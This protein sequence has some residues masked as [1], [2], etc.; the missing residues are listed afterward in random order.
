MPRPSLRARP[1]PP[2]PD[3][4]T[5]TPGSVVAFDQ[6]VRFEPSL[7]GTESAYS[8]T[9]T[10]IIPIVFLGRNIWRLYGPAPELDR[11][12][13]EL[14]HHGHRHRHRHRRPPQLP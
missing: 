2:R 13:R 6:R 12:Q 3:Q 5:E 1:L 14:E 7:H 11:V 9:G 10:L 8:R 4:A